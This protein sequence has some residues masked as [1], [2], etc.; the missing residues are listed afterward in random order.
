MQPQTEQ[1][2][3]G[4]VFTLAGFLLLDLCISLPGISADFLPGTDGATAAPG[5]TP[6]VESPGGLR[7][8]PGATPA[9]GV[10]VH[11]EEGTALLHTPDA[12]VADW[13][14]LE[15]VL[16][17]RRTDALGGYSLIDFT[18]PARGRQTERIEWDGQA[19]F[20]LDGEH[21]MLARSGSTLR[22][23]ELA[24]ILS[25]EGDRLSAAITP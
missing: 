2:C 19:W 1:I 22:R 25:R 8:A 3:I 17:L 16:L 5:S 24:D 10:T 20:T 21:V 18:E 4:V 15:D 6:A 12:L 23:I 11:D 9:D 7:A 14:P 13:S